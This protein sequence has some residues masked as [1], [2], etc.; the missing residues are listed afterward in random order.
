MTNK[1]SGNLL[2]IRFVGAQNRDESVPEVSMALEGTEDA[3]SL[4]IPWLTFVNSP[5]QRGQQ[6]VLTVVEVQFFVT[7]QPS[8]GGRAAVVPQAARARGE[9]L[10]ALWPGLGDAHPND[11]DVKKLPLHERIKF[12]YY[13]ACDKLPAGK[14]MLATGDSFEVD[15]RVAM[16]VLPL[17]LSGPVETNRQY[18]LTV[19]AYFRTGREPDAEEG[20][21]EASCLLSFGP[22]AVRSLSFNSFPGRIAIDFGTTFSTVAL[23]DLLYRPGDGGFPSEQAESLTKGIRDWIDNGSRNGSGEWGRFLKEV[24]QNKTVKSALAMPRLTYYD[25]G[26]ELIREIETVIWQQND[27]VIRYRAI[28]E[29]TEIYHRALRT[30]PLRKFRIFPILLE[31]GAGNYEMES[32]VEIKKLTP[33]VEIDMGPQVRERRQKSGTR[34]TLADRGKPTRA[35]R[36]TFQPSP[37]QFLLD[38]LGDNLDAP[39]VRLGDEKGYMDRNLKMIVLKEV[40]RQLI[41]KTKKSRDGYLKGV[42]SPGEFTSVVATYPTVS[43]PAMREEIKRLL[44]ELGFG[45]TNSNVQYDEAVASAIFYMW[46]EYCN[47]FLDVEGFKVSAI[48]EDGFWKQNLLITDIGG[49]TTDVALIEI[50]LSEKRGTASGGAVTTPNDGGRTAGQQAP[51]QGRYYVVTPRVISTSGHLNYGGNLITLRI[52]ELLKAK[53]ADHF[54][55]ARTAPSGLAANMFESVVVSLDK[56]FKDGGNYKPNSLVDGILNYHESVIASSSAD[57]LV[58][59]PWDGETHTPSTFARV[60]DVADRI[61]PTKFSKKYV[62][63]DM[64]DKRYDAFYYLW[65][66]AE[67]IK[68]EFGGVEPDDARWRKEIS[69]ARVAQVFNL[70]DPTSDPVAARKVKWGPVV[71]S[72]DE[73]KKVVLQLVRVQIRLGVKLSK[74]EG[75]LHWFILSGQ[76]GKMKL[77]NREIERLRE[78]DEKLS[79]IYKYTFISEYSKLSTVLGA[80]F[81][82]FTKNQKLEAVSLIDHGLNQIVFNLQELLYHLPCSFYR[83]VQTGK[84]PVPV[85]EIGGLMRRIDQ[86]DTGKL[87]SAW[88][89]FQGELAFLRQDSNDQEHGWSDY[90]P[91]DKVSKKYKPEALEYM[92]EVDSELNLGMF[93][94]VKGHSAYDLDTAEA[95]AHPKTN[96]MTSLSRFIEQ[97]PADGGVARAKRLSVAIWV[98]DEKGKRHELFP[99]GQ[100]FAELF[101][102][103]GGILG[104]GGQQQQTTV[105]ALLKSIPDGMSDKIKVLA[106][107]GLVATAEVELATV[108]WEER[109]PIF[110]WEHY[111]SLDENGQLRAHYGVPPFYATDDEDEFL[112]EE[113]RGIVLRVRRLPPKR[114]QGRTKLDPFSGEH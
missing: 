16:F 74:K 79:E 55:S 49:G 75:G 41:H 69:A 87:R 83:T 91:P 63:D 94:R 29:L 90:K 10:K 67:E 86:A 65:D 5:E 52:F 89:D 40:Y 77:V 12:A 70:C 47:P 37:K 113:N 96:G 27:E 112:R 109:S 33:G 46:R 68:I 56:T 104:R 24:A 13:F 99:L 36:N 106:I 59:D 1:P 30:P 60:L 9:G 84:Y 85:L 32:E 80:A 105:R 39:E 73:I 23:Y 64:V 44:T 35:P 6:E 110:K 66:L 92:L 71:F 61:I 98:E 7:P 78:T 11:P 101:R 108:A 3:R 107:T 57:S 102:L 18:L 81:M 17:Q 58:A 21:A 48:A 19:R 82:E 88:L 76:T 14:E 97:P 103:K 54:L 62:G 2:E 43:S 93:I 100:E 45:S 8:Q 34:S 72:Y 114:H 26:S 25:A 28:D 38:S 20:E 31:P 15:G 51:T 111:L 50:R 4:L 95:A 22:E 53:L 42:V